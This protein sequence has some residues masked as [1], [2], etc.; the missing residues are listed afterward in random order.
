MSPLVAPTRIAIIMPN[1]L[2]YLQLA[3]VTK[4]AALPAG[5]NISRFW[6]HQRCYELKYLLR[7]IV[8]GGSN[9]QIVILRQH[10]LFLL[11]TILISDFCGALDVI[12]KD[13]FSIKFVPQIYSSSY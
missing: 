13:P 8:L 11:A 6:V 1:Y 9:Q 5:I 2:N 4:C 10:F 7:R 3:K 12:S